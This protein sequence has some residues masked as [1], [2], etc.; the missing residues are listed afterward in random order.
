MDGAQRKE[1]ERGRIGEADETCETDAT[2]RV[3]EPGMGGSWNAGRE[4]VART[5][6]KVARIG[7]R[8]AN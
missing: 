4:K 5:R 3:K 6:A 8:D 1:R 7:V 2:T